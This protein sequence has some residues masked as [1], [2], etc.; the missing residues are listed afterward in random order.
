MAGRTIAA[1]ADNKFQTLN[2]LVRFR[3]VAY[4]GW[5]SDAKSFLRGDGWSIRLIVWIIVCIVAFVALATLGLVHQQQE[6][7]K[8]IQAATESELSAIRAK[9]EPLTANDLAKLHPDPPRERDAAILLEPVSGLLSLKGEQAT[10]IP[11]FGNVMPSNFVPLEASAM[12]E[13]RR[14]LDQN[15]AALDAIPWD[16]LD[17]AWIGGGFTKGFTNLT[18]LPAGMMQLNKLLCLRAV[19][20]AEN[21]DAHSAVESLRRSLLITDTLKGGTPIHYFIQAAAEEHACQVAERIV[22]RTSVSDSD[23][24]TISAVLTMTNAGNTKEM[25]MEERCLGLW[26]AE[27]LKSQAAQRTGGIIIS[28]W[29]KLSR[30]MQGRLIYRDADLLDYL[31]WNRRCLEALDL[32]LSNSVIAL[33]K[34]E[35]EMPSRTYKPSL[36]PFNH[37]S[38]AKLMLQRFPPTRFLLPEASMVADVRA[39]ITALAIERWRLV[40]NRKLP[41]SLRELEPRYLAAPPI[42]PFTDQ[43]L[44]YKKLAKGYMVYSI[45]PN[46]TDDG[47]LVKPSDVIEI[48]ETNHYDI[49]FE[50]NQ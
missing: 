16:Q 30:M 28:P 48:S 44:R 14:L 47:G 6:E 46:F 32:P 11:F 24:M 38:L 19:L 41:D 26:M 1:W 20:D 37:D 40:H 31:E 2:R 7:E 42:D 5:V 36:N 3:H 23:L 17:G 43:L 8:Q 12:V 21:H 50:V 10:S 15:E 22:N 34:I 35:K 49:V 29:R 27:E 25:M 45:G 13:S 33:H 39:T 9:G 4:S 18:H